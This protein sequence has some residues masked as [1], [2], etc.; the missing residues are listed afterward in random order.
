M[1]AKRPPISAGKASRRWRSARCSPSSIPAHEQRIKATPAGGAAGRLCDRVAA[2]CCRSSAFMSGARPRCSTPASARCCATI[3]TVFCARLG[4]AGFRGR[5]LTMQSNGGVMPPEARERLRRQHAAFGAG[6][7]AG[8]RPVLR[9]AVWISNLIT[10]DMGGTSFDVCLIRDGRRSDDQPDPRSRNMRWRFPRSIFTRSGRAAAASPSCAA[11]MLE[12]GPDSAGAAPGPAC[13]GDGGT[14]PTVTDANLVL[15]YLDP[16]NFLGGEKKLRPGRRRARHRDPYRQAA[17]PHA[18][19]RPRSGS[20]GWW[21]RR[22]PTACGRCP[23]RAASIRATPA[24]SRR[25]VP[26]RC[27]PAASPMNSA[28]S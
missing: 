27:M 11:A 5:F 26:G 20:C 28:W 4:E 8:R 10:V 15:G 19:G 6:K 9:Q 1:C 24:L 23:W 7:R 16:D 21:T 17:G 13:Y 2:K 22:W 12:V 3:L 18:R 25:A 14:L